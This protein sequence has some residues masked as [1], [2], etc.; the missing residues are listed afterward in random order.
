MY[1]KGGNAVIYVRG[2]PY[3][4]AQ[5][6]ILQYDLK[7]IGIDSS[8]NQYSASVFYTKAGTKGEPFDA[9]IG[10]WGWDYPDPFDFLNVFFD[11]NLIQ[12]DHNV[13]LSYFN[14]PKFNTLMEAASRQAGAARYS[15]Y[16]KLDHELMAGPAP[17]APYINTN[18]R[19]L[20]SKHV[21]C[22]V[23][24]QTYGSILNAACVS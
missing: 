15:A 10:A 14:S 8:I 1:S 22:Y 4:L 20:M 23:Y 24:S 5:G 19:I 6:Q 21:G 7:Q 11:G 18:A 9:A 13:N 3:Q 12:A 16:A 2:R 17:L